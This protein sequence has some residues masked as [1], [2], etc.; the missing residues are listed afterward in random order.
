MIEWVEWID[1]VGWGGVIGCCERVCIDVVSLLG[2][3]R[4][5]VDWLAGSCILC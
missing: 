2:I 3:G 4:I 1:R 5:V